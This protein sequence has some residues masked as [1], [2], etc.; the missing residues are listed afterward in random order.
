[1]ARDRSCRSHVAR[2]RRARCAAL[3][4]VSLLVAGCSSGGAKQS[5]PT[6]TTLGMPTGVPGGGTSVPADNLDPCPKT[7]DPA[8]LEGAS[9]SRMDV[10]V[11]RLDKELVPITSSR[12]RVCRYGTSRQLIGEEALTAPIAARFRTAS[13]RLAGSV[14]GNVGPTGPLA[15]DVVTFANNTQ[16]VSLSVNLSGF[17]VTNG[18][19]YARPTPT[20]FNELLRHTST[21][22]PG[23][24]VRTG[25]SNPSGPG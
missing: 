3:A 8:N 18:Y 5:A 20:W 9:L 23:P 14:P 17:G 19:L 21:T 6:T 2:G 22:Q 13:N 16:R 24:A 1:M 25:S 7:Y 4:A 12:V 15:V 10:G 11:Q